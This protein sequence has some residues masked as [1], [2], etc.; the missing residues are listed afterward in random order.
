MF[1]DASSFEARLFAPG[2]SGSYSYLPKN[3][4]IGFR[5]SF[6]TGTN[7]HSFGL[8]YKV[9]SSIEPITDDSSCETITA[10]FPNVPTIRQRLQLDEAWSYDM[11]FVPAFSFP[12]S[13]ACLHSNTQVIVVDADDIYDVTPN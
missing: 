7:S 12:E 10:N 13:A 9:L 11:S 8:E 5:T 3:R 2:N 4:L 1:S 6:S